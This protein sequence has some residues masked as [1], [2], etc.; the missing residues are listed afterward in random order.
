KL[1][2]NAIST[3]AMV[4]VG[5]TYGNYMVDVTVSNVKLRDRALR[6]IQKLT[7]CDRSTAESLLEAAHLRVKPALLM[8]WANCSYDTAVKTLAACNGN[9][10]EARRQLS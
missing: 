9:L 2:L 7:D 8:H 6:T 4:Q 10:R 5:K 1:V 3:G